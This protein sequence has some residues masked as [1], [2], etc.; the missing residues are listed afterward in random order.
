M[1]ILT[2]TY[3]INDLELIDEKGIIWFRIPQKY[4]R[5]VHCEYEYKE[6]CLGHLKETLCREERLR[7]KFVKKFENGKRL[8]Q[9]RFFVLC[10]GGYEVF[11]D[12]MILLREDEL[13]TG[14][15]GF[16]GVKKNGNN[17]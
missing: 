9:T 5:C 7:N 12:F 14:S 15:F 16:F 2:Q 1:V 6:R 10:H 3:D 8:Y 4:G 11:V 13:D 17:L